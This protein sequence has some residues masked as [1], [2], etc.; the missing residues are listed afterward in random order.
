MTTAPLFGLLEG[1]DAQRGRI[2]R[3]A[4]SELK[5]IPPETVTFDPEHGLYEAARR[6]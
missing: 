2:E 3:D 4:F 5:A 6:A 1:F